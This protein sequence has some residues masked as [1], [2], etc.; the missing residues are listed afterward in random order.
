MFT[1]IVFEGKGSTS[2]IGNYS[3]MWVSGTLTYSGV[4]ILA[5]ITILYASN[6]HT[7][8]SILII[9]LSIWLFFFYFWFETILPF[10]PELYQVFFFTSQSE[11]LF[12]YLF[13]LLGTI[14][15]AEMIVYKAGQLL[16]KPIEEI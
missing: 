2:N 6:N 5:N 15:I 1:F 11:Q 9:L 8:W 3:S 12:F 16:V 14:L 10:I 4:V 13:F 7:I